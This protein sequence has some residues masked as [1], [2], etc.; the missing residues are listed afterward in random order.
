MDK[1]V[2]STAYPGAPPEE[3]E[4]LVTVPIEKELKGVD[5]ID[6][7]YSASDENVS[8]IMISIS[9]DAKDKA[10]VVDDIQQAVDQV[11]DLPGDAEDPI[12]TEITTGEVPTVEIA[13]SGDLTETELRKYA[14]NL[15]DILDD[16]PG[17]SSIS[18]R[19]WRDR[20]VWVEVDPDKMRD[21]HVSM[22]EVMDSLRERNISI[23][24]G[25]LRGEKEFSIRT[26]GEF[27]KTQ[28]IENVIIRANDLGNWLR[29]KDI[30]SVRFSFKEEN[31]INKSF[32][33]R[34]INL[35]VIKKSTG[36][37]VKIVKMVK[38]KTTDFIHASDPR[39]EV[40]YINDMSFYI[41]RRL[42]VLR[43]NGIFGLFLV[44]CVLMLFLNY[45]VAILTALGIPIA[46]CATLTIMG[47]MGLRSEEHTSEL[48]SH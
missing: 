34:S 47:F 13:L 18:R 42:G 31:V 32:G 3:I 27:H 19:G 12:V 26:T 35:T 40:S 17:V 22:E 23:P 46:F 30:A 37:T 8:T 4:K 7:M 38:E 24:G 21:F 9:H 2:I 28:E 14:E 15:E 1:V 16:I 44:M 43:N 39:L 11:Q 36:D 48:Q 33:M 41:T 25:K 20:E 6:E 5:G 10:K 45:R 29:I